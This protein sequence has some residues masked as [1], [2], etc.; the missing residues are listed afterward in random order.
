[1]MQLRTSPASPF[2]RK[3]QLAAALL[4]LSDEI[5]IV[6]TDTSDPASGL[7]EVNPL[8]KIPTLTLDDK[9]TYYDS[10]VIVD[11]LDHRAARDGRV[12]AG[13]IPAE[14]AARFRALTQAALADG[15]MEASLAQ[16]YE[17]RARK[18]DKQDPAWIEKHAG[19]AAR[20]LAAFEAAPPDGARSV[21][22]V[23]LAAALGY[24]DLRFAGAWR[25]SHP[26]LVAWLAAFAAETPAFA[27]TAA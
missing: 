5:E 12:G 23:G 17:V 26:K 25:E 13:L 1:M 20:A 19:K 15:L 4:G 3:V 10:R 22:D 6:P 7:L 14:P 24:L 27:L 9:T 8:G 16:I 2:G 11:Y 21:A 18:A